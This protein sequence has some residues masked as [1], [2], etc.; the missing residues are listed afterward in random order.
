MSATNRLRSFMF[1]IRKGIGIGRDKWPDSFFQGL[2][3]ILLFSDLEEADRIVLSACGA[4][5]SRI[6][7]ICPIL[8]HQIDSSGLLPSGR[9]THDESFYPCSSPIGAPMQRSMISNRDYAF[10]VVELLELFSPSFHGATCAIL[11][12]WSRWRGLGMTT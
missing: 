11:S 10:G 8:V 7:R 6:S 12:V 1:R 4:I 5:P 2:P 9:L 3:I